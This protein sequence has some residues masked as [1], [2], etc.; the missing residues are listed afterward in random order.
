MSENCKTFHIVLNIPSANNI[1]A[2]YWLLHVFFYCKIDGEIT[3]I[4]GET[5]TVEVKVSEWKMQE[6]LR[7]F[8]TRK[9]ECRIKE[10]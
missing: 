1:I 6:L 2:L 7:S 9:V 5:F 8:E 4:E 10:N 3:D